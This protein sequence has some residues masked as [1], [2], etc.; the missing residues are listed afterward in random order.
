MRKT[1]LLALGLFL[2]VSSV[3]LAQSTDN[4]NDMI[5]KLVP[6]EATPALAPEVETVLTVQTATKNEILGRLGFSASRSLGK[7][8]A[9]AQLPPFAKGRETELLAALKPL[10]SVQVAVAFQGASDA[11][12]PDAGPLLGQLAQALSDSKLSA[13]RVVIGVHTNSVGSDE[14]NLDLSTLR[15]KAIVDALAVM[16]GVSRD[17]LVAF[18]F[19]RIHDGA[20]QGV[21]PDERIQVVNLGA[22]P[23]SDSVTRTPVARA[24][25][26]APAVRPAVRVF[27][28]FSRPAVFHPPAHAK[29]NF[30]ATMAGFGHP[31]RHYRPAPD[32]YEEQDGPPVRGFANDPYSAPSYV[33]PRYAVGGGGGGG[34]GGGGA[35]GGG[36][37]GGGAGGGGAGGGGAGGGGAGGGGAGGG[38][39]GGGGAGGG[40]AGGGGGGG[41]SDR[42][43]KRH[44]RR[45]GATDH[46]IPLYSFQYIWGGPFF[47]GVMAQDLLLT[48]PEAVLSGS[49]GYM[50]V[51]YDRLGIR[52]MTLAEWDKA[53]AHCLT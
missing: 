23:T 7:A 47:V 11:L 43:L 17:R 34:A 22:L 28:R 19:G 29:R 6:S 53:Q 41:W 27:P 12:A 51:D 42:R 50:L 8:P 32:Y 46:G 40:G 15:A 31:P 2:S 13:S 18:G 30:G 48:H 21:M 38:G 33:T 26:I 45:V 37:G 35:G 39:A 49:G 20:S 10:P 24:A 36:A 9:P 25:S 16:H 1:G 14:Y 44:I 5:N 3:A 52:M 4:A